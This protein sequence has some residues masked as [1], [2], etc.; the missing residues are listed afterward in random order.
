MNYS[1]VR[2]SKNCEILVKSEQGNKWQQCSK[3][4]KKIQKEASHAHTTVTVQ[5]PVS[6]A[7]AK[8]PLSKLS[9]AKLQATVGD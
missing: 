9:T 3:V 4:H 5:G 6:P 8:A 7:N 2:R 1:Q